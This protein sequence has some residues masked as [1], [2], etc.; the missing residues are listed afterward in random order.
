M[1]VAVIAALYLSA[2]PTVLLA[3]SAAAL[4][5]APP[6]RYSTSATL[7]GALIADPAARAVLDKYMPGIGNS[8]VIVYNT[9]LKGIQGY[10]GG[11]L[12]D[13]IL[14]QM[15]ADLAKLTPKPWAGAPARPPRI[16]NFDEAKV[17]PYTLPDPLVL[18]DGQPV[19]D[20]QTWRTK[21]RPEI[22]AMFETN[23]YGRAPGRPPEERFEVFD[24]GSPA[25]GGKATRKQVMIHLS[26]DAK[27]PQIQLV[28]YIPAAARKR[29]PMLLLIG[30]TTPAMMIDD[31]GIRPGLVW[32]P[33]KKQ[34]VP[35]SQAP[36]MGK[37]NIDRFL[38][39]GIGVATWYYGDVDPDFQGGYDL[40]V[41]AL[42]D[43][44]DEAHRAPDAWGAI[45]AWS[46]SFS[47]VQDYL[48]T[49]PDVDAKR[50]AIHGASRLGR[51][52]LWAGAHDQRF[53]AVI[54]CCSGKG[55]AALYHRNYA[56]GIVKDETGGND[57]WYARNMKMFSERESEL[58]M[59]GHML[60]SLIAPRAVLLQTGKQDNAADPKGEFLG[61]VAAGPV[62][63]LLGKQ[64]LGTTT[65]PP[66][67]PILHDIGYTM[68][69]G[70]HG[71]D[72]GDW[73]VYLAFL[74]QHLHPEK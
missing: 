8:S 44:V 23:M 21:R 16:P 58:P 26:K 29:V 63:R 55:G 33:A 67:G 46:W 25:L 34:K 43:K 49:D 4:A 36:G 37:M 40:G 22:V 27:A 74:K 56:E 3:Q 41:R 17:G 6:E 28:E 32:D 54:A 64:D 13:E 14:A 15:D 31:P 47:R 39:A 53:A 9:T 59:D 19:R 72:P 52:V 45:A 60:L 62:Y 12:T 73:D 42:L 20:A 48:E 50:V 38:D 57:H 30:F 66:G 10:S 51:S 65:W 1:R 18:K 2:M 61:A 70:G 24:K 11:K 35:A 71:I 7:L 69:A 5:G 68:H